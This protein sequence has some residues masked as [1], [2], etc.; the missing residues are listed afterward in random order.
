MSGAG[1]DWTDDDVRAPAPRTVAEL[2]AGLRERLAAGAVDAPLLEDF[3]LFVAVRLQQGYT[4]SAVEDEL[5]GWG[6]GASFV[7]DTVCDVRSPG[8]P[9]VTPVRVADN[10]FVRNGP[11]ATD[12]GYREEARDRAVARGDRR[13]REA[14]RMV[15]AEPAERVDLG[16]TPDRLPSRPSPGAARAARRWPAALAVVFAAVLAL[17]VGIAVW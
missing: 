7:I 17:L 6:L 2:Y 15:D 8:A 3:R 14:R 16:F 13:M 11:T 12:G 9:R 5:I 10:V 4:Q 1:D